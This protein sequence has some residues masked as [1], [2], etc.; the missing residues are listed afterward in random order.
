[1]KRN[2]SKTAITADNL[3]SL[4]TEKLARIILAEADVNGGFRKLVKA[5]LAGA[6][7]GDAIAKLIDRRLAGLEKAR[8][9]IDWR[10]EQ[11]FAAELATLVR[12]IAGE[13]AEQDLRAATGR[14]VRF[15]ATHPTVFERIDDSSGRI[16]RVYAEAVEDCGNLFAKLAADERSWLPALLTGMLQTDTHGLTGDLI[17]RLAPLLG[18][19]DCVAFDN[20]LALLQ[21]T[22]P[23][24]ELHNRKE[25]T[26][27]PRFEALDGEV[28]ALMRALQVGAVIDARQSLADAR[29]D[30]D[31]YIALENT[32]LPHVRDTYAIAIRLHRANRHADALMAIRTDGSHASR[33]P[34][35]WRE[36]AHAAAFADPLPSLLHVR[37]EAEILTSLGDRPEAQALRWKAFERLLDVG[38]LREHLAAADD[39]AEFEIMDRAFSAADRHDDPYRALAFYID[40][41]DLP[42]AAALVLARRSEWSGDHYDFLPEAARTLETDHPLE[43]TVLYRALLSDILDRARARAYG[44]AARY[45]TRLD[46][47]ATLVEPWPD[48]IA[49]HSVFRSE[50]EANHK[51]KTGFWAQSSLLA[52]SAS[53]RQFK[54]GQRK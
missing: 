12:M 50:I 2:D 24:K 38:L 10:K 43:A 52:A 19:D 37:L 41:P 3:V 40:L 29:G 44:Y 9:M 11:A 22:A 49:P 31:L 1:M 46:D 30:V 36:R 54:A 32:K 34:L 25:K 15:I 21:E 23:K 45:L 48:A 20:A 26:T 28:D 27:P 5:V 17:D 13:L 35:A 42:R 6:K 8:S 18:R 16:Q 47:L 33:I 53:P 4:G 14:L 51:R 7:G 39:F